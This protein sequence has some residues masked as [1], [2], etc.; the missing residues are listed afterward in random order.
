MGRRGKEREPHIAFPTIMQFHSC[1]SCYCC[2]SAPENKFKILLNIHVHY[3][4]H[5]VN[6]LCGVVGYIILL[7]I[8]QV[9]WLENG[10][11]FVQY[12]LGGGIM[13]I[14]YVGRQNIFFVQY[15]LGGVVGYIFAQ[16]ILG[17]WI[18]DI[19]FCNIFQVG[20][21]LDISPLRLDPTHPFNA[22]T[23]PAAEGRG[24]IMNFVPESSSKHRII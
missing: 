6:I 9:G 14:F 21:W 5:K 11:N 23:P 16:Y 17:G 2:S 8:F 1:C 4:L 20:W 24:G 13:D 7:Y 19:S 22:T 10:Y 18:I 12:I 15:I 3:V